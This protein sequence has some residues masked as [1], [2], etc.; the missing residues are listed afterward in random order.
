MP[1]A[2]RVSWAKFRVTAVSTVALLIL[3]TISYLL[4]GGTLFEAKSNLY[5]Y[6]PDATGL[7]AGLPVRVSGISVGKI[8][9]VELSGSRDPN[10]MIK[11]T[12][13]VERERLASIAP[14][15]TAQVASDSAL[16]D[17][18][19]AITSGTQPD[20]VRPNAE[21]PYK[22]APEMLKT[23]DLEQFQKKV[24]AIDA[25]FQDIESGK[26]RVGEFVKGDQVYRRLLARVDEVEHGV[27]AVADTRDA[28]G[29]ELYTD[30]LFQQVHAP[31]AELDQKLAQ[32]QAGQGSTGKLL[33]SPA[34][35][36]DM[37]NRLGRLR[38]TV[39][40]LAKQPMM[41]SDQ[42][43]NDWNRQVVAIIQ[44]VNDFN[45]SPMMITPSV[46]ENVNGA[47]RE[48]QQGAKEFRENPKKFLRLKI[49]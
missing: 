15:S 42:A 43:Y 46:Y 44:R 25:L 6:L 40:D 20:R 49:F 45:A 22:G 38:N 11:V 13:V 16:G 34:Q 30:R 1:S 7:L 26:S 39:A 9:V 36:E 5:L 10:R 47:L 33:R 41:N 4:T 17:K 48:M 35:Y 2:Q 23:L 12:M 18:Y 28:V 32:W 19:V 27:K 31:L 37:R 3:G 14:D 24:D 21:I 8:A 29:R